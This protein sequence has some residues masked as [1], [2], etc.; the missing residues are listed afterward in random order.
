MAAVISLPFDRY[1]NLLA[2]ILERVEREPDAAA[3]VVIDDDGTRHELDV[4]TVHRDALA[5]AARL[6]S[7]GIRAGDVVILVMGHGRGLVSTF[8]GALYLGAVPTIFPYLT[9]KLDPAF[10]ASRVRAMVA[11]AGATAV[12]VGTDFRDQLATVLRDASCR[13]IAD[14]AL[15]EGRGVESRPVAP[16]REDVAYL[17]F[18]SGTSGTQKGVPLTHDMLLRYIEHNLPAERF[19]REDVIVSWLPLY[20]DLGL[21]TG[22]LLPLVLGIRTI[23]MSAFRWVRDPKVLF[24]VGHAFRGTMCWMPNFALNHCVETIRDPDDAGLDLGHWRNLILG[25]EPVRL[26]SLRRFEAHFRPHGLRERVVQTGYG[27]A[28]NVC[29]VTISDRARPVSVDWIDG[30]TLEQQRRAESARAGAPGA[31]AIV[32]CGQAY[33]GTEMRIIGERGDVLPDRRVGEVAVRGAYLFGGYHRRPDL[34]AQALRDGWFMTGDLGYVVDGEL[35]L[36]GRQSDL[37]IVGGRNVQPDE[38][39]TM[40]ADVPGLRAGRAVAFGVA[41]ERSGTERVVLVCETRPDVDAGRRAEIA[42]VLR[43]RAAQEHDL[44]LA[45]VRLVESGWVIKTSN[46]K[47]ARPANREKYLAAFGAR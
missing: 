32:T 6:A 26:D 35:Y 8:L 33:P 45:D 2:P 44:V 28:E 36:C 43:R 20:H 7:L 19:T 5:D 34:S 18:T 17:Q 37:I 15:A 41:D 16:R 22:V 30:R 40:A 47:L 39:E 9:P 3:L 38:L 13:V 10:Y 25:G 21:V 46:G 11:S 24:Q 23:L 42:A 27:M 12:V 14:D 4:A 29:A 1:P 31:I